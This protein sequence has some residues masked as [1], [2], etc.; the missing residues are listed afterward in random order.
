M[1]RGLLVSIMMSMALVVKAAVPSYTN[2]ILPYDYSDPDVCRVGNMYL[3]TSSSFNNV[4]SLQI[5]AS[6]DLV[7]WKI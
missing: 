6:E 5:L 7:H 2:P 3:M 4:P 1:R